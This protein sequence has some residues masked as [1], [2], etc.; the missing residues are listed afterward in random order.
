[1][2]AVQATGRIQGRRWFSLPPELSAALSCLTFAESQHVVS[3][4]NP[5]IF[6]RLCRLLPLALED[7]FAFSSWHWSKTHLLGNTPT[8]P[9]AKSWIPRFSTFQT[10][11]LSERLSSSP[12]LKSACWV[13]LSV[14]HTKNGHL[15]CSHRVFYDRIIGQMT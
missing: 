11:G 1:M 13:G 5:K 8:A 4:C 15:L 7:L 2:Y 14:Q 12:L 6:L 3:L 9:V 10:L